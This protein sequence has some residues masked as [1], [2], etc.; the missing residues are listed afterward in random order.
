M[1]RNRSARSFVLVAVVCILLVGPYLGPPA[2]DVYESP[3]N[4]SARR[5]FAFRIDFLLLLWAVIKIKN[6]S[7]R[8][9]IFYP[10]SFVMLLSPQ[11]T[12]GSP[13]FNMKTPTLLLLPPATT[14][15]LP[16]SVTDLPVK[17]MGKQLVAA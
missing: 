11:R 3:P 1:T 6:L 2:L 15:T 7:A 10:L 17:L 8:A 9:F 4:Y 13:I 14:I 5:I 16:F 12:N